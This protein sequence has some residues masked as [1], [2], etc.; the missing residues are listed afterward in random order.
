MRYPQ[1][2]RR[3]GPQGAGPPGGDRG[4]AAGDPVP[5]PKV[6]PISSLA[7]PQGSCCSQA[8]APSHWV[9][10][11]APFLTAG[12]AGGPGPQYRRKRR[13]QGF[14]G[15]E[16]GRAPIQPGLLQRPL[17]A[18]GSERARRRSGAGFKPHWAPD[19]R[20]K[21]TLEKPVHHRGPG[22]VWD[23]ARGGSDGS[24]GLPAR[25]LLAQRKARSLCEAA[26]KSPHTI[27]ASLPPVSSI[28]GECRQVAP[29]P[30]PSPTHGR[31]ASSIQGKCGLKVVPGPLPSP[32]AQGGAV[33]TTLSEVG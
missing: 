33:Q 2:A 10:I 29:S 25:G 7:A 17:P 19:S 24:A 3:V 15:G 8:T 16:K 4:P 9:L 14:H 5:G 26:P 1:T 18:A 23:G 11:W 30:L 28:Q 6:T 27:A 20:R 21:W 22:W 13:L 31:A 32:P 12:R